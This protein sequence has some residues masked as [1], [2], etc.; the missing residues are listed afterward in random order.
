MDGN[1]LHQNQVTNESAGEVDGRTSSMMMEKY[2][3]DAESLIKRYHGSQDKRRPKEDVKTM[4][5]DHSQGFKSAFDNNDPRD[6]NSP[7]PQL[8]TERESENRGSTN[9]VNTMAPSPVS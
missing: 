6:L 5:G 1:L 7:H 4:V 3:Q 2:D 8:H 9:Q